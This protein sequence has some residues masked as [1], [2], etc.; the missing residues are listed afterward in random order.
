MTTGDLI[1]G[2]VIAL[3]VIAAIAS[4]VHGRRKGKNSCGCNCGCCPKGPS[5]VTIDEG[6]PKGKKDD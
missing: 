1:V 6:D 2:A 4:I 5:L 3:M